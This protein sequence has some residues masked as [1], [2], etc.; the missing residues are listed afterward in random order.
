[1]IY[2]DASAIVKLVVDEAETGALQAWLRRRRSPLV[3]SDL[4][5]VEV[6]RA[7]MRAQPEVLLDAQRA[8]A[9]LATVPLTPRLL[10]A[11]A[12]LRPPS[13]RTLDA[14]H[15]ASALALGSPLR[16]FVAYDHRL[17]EAAID[18]DLTVVAPS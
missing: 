1:M 4:S 7:C 10:A 6:V 12:T 13:L 16:A 8:V 14:I 17:A 3:T 9:R 15:V 11:A 18:H 5:R 2:L